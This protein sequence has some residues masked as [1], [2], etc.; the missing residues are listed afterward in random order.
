MVSKR[1]GLFVTI[2][3]PDG[4]GK[5]T[6]LA[7][8]LRF[9][10]ERNIDYVATR[11]PGGTPI[12]EKL[13]EMVLHEKMHLET[14]ALLM[15]AS[16]REHIEQVIRPALER[17]VCVVSDRFTD[18][19]FAFQGGGRGLDLRKLE[20]LEDWVQ[21]GL[22]PDLTIVLDVDIAVA[23]ARMAGSRNLDRFEQEERVFHER[24]REEYLRRAEQFPDRIKVVNATRSIAEV[25]ADIE[26]V[27]ATF[28]DAHASKR[29]RPR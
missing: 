5:S 8:M 14:E 18:A 25:G 20:I 6:N 23:S 27:L 2:D 12:G 22:Q 3:G 10:D 4:G 28:F 24:V 9:L 21:E 15:F 1:R 16:R 13:R 7:T 11:E 26:D 29:P 19:S 17:G